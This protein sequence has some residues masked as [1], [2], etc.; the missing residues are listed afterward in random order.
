MS[1]SVQKSKVPSRKSSEIKFREPRPSDGSAVHALIAACPPL[2]VNS[3]YA[4]LLMCSHFAATCVVAES[5]EGILGFIS[6]YPRPD[7]P[8]T[9]FVWQVA[10]SSAARGQGLAGRMLD[11]IVQRHSC[12][13]LHRMETTVSPTNRASEMVFRKFA[14]RHGAAVETSALFECS[15]FGN[16]NHEEEVL[17]TIGPLNMGAAKPN[18]VEV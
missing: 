7:C 9:L 3:C 16:E 13:G 4:Y 12:Q 17:F 15:D 10:V 11:A 14:N 5:P 2:D 1:F 18:R 6:A 8:H